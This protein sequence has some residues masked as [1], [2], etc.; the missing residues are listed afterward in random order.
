[1]A[2]QALLWSTVSLFYFLSISHSLLNGWIDKARVRNSGL[3]NPS[4]Q[5]LN[6]IKSET[7]RD[8]LRYLVMKIDYTW[9]DKDITGKEMKHSIIFNTKLYSNINDIQ[10]SMVFE[11]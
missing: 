5:Y 8:C 6:C 10:I 9:H 3:V 2:Y 7:G 11:L 4:I 1:M